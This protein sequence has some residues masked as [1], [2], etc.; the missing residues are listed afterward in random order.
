ML[1]VLNFLEEDLHCDDYVIIVSKA[2]FLA[3]PQHV[4]RLESDNH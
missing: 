2:D 4:G 1:A 3:F